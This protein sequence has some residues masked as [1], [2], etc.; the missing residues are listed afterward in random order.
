M[1]QHGVE[2]ERRYNEIKAIRKRKKD[3][4]EQ[5]VNEAFNH[6][7]QNI[8]PLFEEVQII[9]S[10]DI[11]R[12]VV[13]IE[14]AVPTQQSPYRAELSICI[15]SDGEKISF[16]YDGKTFYRTKDVEDDFIYWYC[17]DILCQS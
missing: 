1:F 4:L 6:Q 3:E 17:H 14:W 7:F 2:L 9:H 8:L 11:D 10:I 5:K 12:G 13:I 15:S 16:E